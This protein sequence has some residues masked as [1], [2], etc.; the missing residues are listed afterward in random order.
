MSMGKNRQE[1]TPDGSQHQRDTTLAVRTHSSGT[2]KLTK[3][4]FRNLPYKVKD[5]LSGKIYLEKNLLTPI[6]E[7]LTNTQLSLAL[8][9]ITQL[10]NI[11][12]PVI[13]AIRAISYLLEEENTNLTAEKVALK[14]VAALSQHIA[15]LQ[16][17]TSNLGEHVNSTT[18]QTNSTSLETLTKISDTVNNIKCSLESI[19]NNPPTQ[20]LPNRTK[21]PDPTAMSLR[22]TTTS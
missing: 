7:Q 12:K 14:T 19:K 21:R 4:E 1:P 17:I 15:K 16:D 3:E 13:E 2:A 10:Q 5:A 6:G 11:P 22:T 9:H 8:L 20:T 18:T